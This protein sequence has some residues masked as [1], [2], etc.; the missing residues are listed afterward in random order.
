M[1]KT[2][3]IIT[4]GCQMNENDSEK[5]SGIIK[6]M[7]YTRTDNL[8]KASLI[9]INTCSIRENADVKFFGFL[10]SLKHYKKDNPEQVLAVCGCMMQQERIIEKIIKTYHQVDI[11][12]G[13]HNIHRFSNLLSEFLMNR[14]QLIDIWEDN[15]KIVEGLPVDHKHT[16]KSY[17]TIM[18]GCNN[19]CTFCIVPHT[20]GREVSRH[21]QNIISEVRKLGKTPCVEVTLLGQNVNSYGKDLKENYNFANLLV[22]LNQVDGIERIRFMTSHPKDMSD[23]V[24]EA[25][26]NCD[27]VCPSIH[28]A[29]QSG[30]T[31][32]LK[33]MNRR[34]S[35]ENILSLVSKIRERIPGVSI[36][37]DLIVGFPGET[38]ADFQD[39]LDVVEACNFD[40]AFSFI[41]SIREGTPAAKMKDQIDDEIKHQRMDR[42][43]DLIRKLSKGQNVKFLNQTVDV[44]VESQIKNE[45]Y[46]LMGRTPSGKIVNLNGEDDIIGKIVPVHIDDIQSFSLKGTQV[47]DERRNIWG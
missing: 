40:S 3:E 13:T 47:L 39:T 28:L 30:S 15:N 5:L 42:L 34:Y 25:I 27:K 7:G 18:N 44:L 45:N 6:S 9:I 26:A 38:E 4:Y 2:Y 23:D 10:G 14:K 21:P 43:L 33:K 41:Y 16:F 36:T 11:I 46:R 8:E 24:I 35:K 12:F 22:D 20:R 32:L 1:N 29:I 37:T 31:K 19:F 17:V